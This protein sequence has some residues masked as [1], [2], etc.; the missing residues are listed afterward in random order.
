[1]AEWTFPK[2][3]YP[4]PLVTSH[5]VYRAAYVEGG[6]VGT[7]HQTSDVLGQ[8]MYR[9]TFAGADGDPIAVDDSPFA[10]WEGLRPDVRLHLQVRVQGDDAIS[11]WASDDGARSWERVTAE[12]LR[13]MWQGIRGQ[14]PG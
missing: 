3:K 6:I 1:M 8:G 7:C 9:W 4:A 5:A 12:S 2:G 14:E 11:E 10:L 13:A